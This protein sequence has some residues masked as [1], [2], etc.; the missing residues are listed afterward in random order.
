MPRVFLHFEYYTSEKARDPLIELGHL[1]AHK[2]RDNNAVVDISPQYKKNS[3]TSIITITTTANP[4]AVRNAVFP[5]ASKYFHIL[6]RRATVF[7]N[8]FGSDFKIVVQAP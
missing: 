3:K 5:V 1:I 7:C 4:S 2:T 6:K 8:H